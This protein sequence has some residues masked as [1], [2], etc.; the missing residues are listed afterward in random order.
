MLQNLV[1][2]YAGTGPGDSSGPTFYTDA[3]GNEILVSLTCQGDPNLVAMGVS[4]RVD[5]ESA[6]AFLASVLA[7]VQ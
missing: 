4:L 6:Q 5:T 7:S 2:G 3:Q 1:A